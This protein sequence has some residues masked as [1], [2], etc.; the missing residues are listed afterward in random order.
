MLGPDAQR[1]IRALAARFKRF[2]KRG[3]RGDRRGVIYVA[4][5]VK[6]IFLVDNLSGSAGRK[7]RRLLRA[8]CLAGVEALRSMDCRKSGRRARAGAPLAAHAYPRLA[9]G[10]VGCAESICWAR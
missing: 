10:G 4:C 2:D 9:R 1:R 8:T 6:A 5:H 7:V 3:A